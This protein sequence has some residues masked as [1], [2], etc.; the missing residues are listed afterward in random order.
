MEMERN[1]EAKVRA[2]FI[3]VILGERA[4]GLILA[5]IIQSGSTQLSRTAIVLIASLDS[6]RHRYLGRPKNKT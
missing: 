4:Y 6:P 2:G 1:N 5:R 3:H